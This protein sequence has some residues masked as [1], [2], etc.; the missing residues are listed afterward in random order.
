[1]NQTKLFVEAETAYEKAKK[2]F[3]DLTIDGKK[4]VMLNILSDHP[5]IHK[6]CHQKWPSNKKEGLAVL[7][8]RRSNG[9]FALMPNRSLGWEKM[10]EVVK[11]LR[12]KVN[13]ARGSEP[14]KFRDLDAEEVLG[15]VPELHFAKATGIISNGSK[16]DTDVPS[17][18]GKELSVEDIIDAVIIGLEETV[19]PKRF[20]EGC[21]KGVC[22]KGACPFYNFSLMRC[23]NIRNLVNNMT[24]VNNTEDQKVV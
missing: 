5:I 19:F 17:L 21:L 13:F 4:M 12:Q 3:V 1:M 22:V 9:Q 6:V 23:H 2:D 15:T 11:I 16:A 8:I 7:F 20:K 18:I 14:I 10:L 24:V